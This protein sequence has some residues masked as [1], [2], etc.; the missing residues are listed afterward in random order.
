[1]AFDEIA[2]PIKTRPV[3][4]GKMQLAAIVAPCA[5]AIPWAVVNTAV[6]H[7]DAGFR[8]EPGRV[9]EYLL[10]NVVPIADQGSAH[11]VQAVGYVDRYL[12]A[13]HTHGLVLER[14]SRPVGP[15]GAASAEGSTDW[16]TV[17][18]A[19]AD[20]ATVAGTTPAHAVARAN[21]AR[22]AALRAL[23]FM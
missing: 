12:P 14:S 5:L 11:L 17:A 15:R 4:E 20:C 19:S 10:G 6:E 13:G 7:L 2:A 8:V 18:R 3:Q 1:L 21:P 23:V 16:A 9:V 22:I